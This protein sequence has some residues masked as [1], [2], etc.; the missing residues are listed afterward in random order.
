MITVGST[1]RT[2][3]GSFEGRVLGRHG[4]ANGVGGSY[5]YKSLPGNLN[6]QVYMVVNDAGEVR[7][8]IGSAL[9]L[10]ED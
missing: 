4:A 2:R 10:V 7:L 3:D 5:E 1:V 6:I 9:A 8:F